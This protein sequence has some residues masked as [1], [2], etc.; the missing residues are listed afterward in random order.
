[1]SVRNARSTVPGDRSTVVPARSIYDFI[2]L[3]VSHIDLTGLRTDEDKYGA[4]AEF[5]NISAV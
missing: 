2:S 1:L 5:L 3:L 4:S